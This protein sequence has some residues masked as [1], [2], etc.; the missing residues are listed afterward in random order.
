M[1]MPRI[2]MS[3]ECSRQPQEPLHQRREVR[4][5]QARDRVPPAQRGEPVRAA[6]RVRPVRDVVERVCEPVR[7][8]LSTLRVSVSPPAPLPMR[9]TYRGVNPPDRRLV[10]REPRVVHRGEDRGEDRRRR[11]RAAR[12]RVVRVD[13]G[14]GREPVRAHVRDPAPAAVEQARVDA[15][16]ELLQVPR[17]LPFLEFGAREDVGEAA[18]GAEERRCALG[19]VYLRA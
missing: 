18:A 5:A 4:R 15:V 13:D 14:D 8:Y 7:V 19:V 16:P 3:L 2:P 17:D 9:C 1:I 6:P 11:G 10:R 12:E